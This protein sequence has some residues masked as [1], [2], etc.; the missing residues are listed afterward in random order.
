MNPTTLQQERLCQII[1]EPVI[2]EKTTR[3]ADKHQ[4][5]VFR[6]VPD[7]SKHEIQQAVEK[8]FEVKVLK[9]QVSNV[10][11]KTK[12]IGR[13]SG[14]RKDWKKAYVRLQEGDD[15]DFLGGGPSS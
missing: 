6:V 10:R 3:I 9:V 8:L 2:S 14:K 13:I 15:I 7:A 12:Q 1:L 5:I 4:Q 11:G